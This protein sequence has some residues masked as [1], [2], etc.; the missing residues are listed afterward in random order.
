MLPFQL[1][2]SL[3]SLHRMAAKPNNTLNDKGIRRSA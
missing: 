1:E 2:V 3:P